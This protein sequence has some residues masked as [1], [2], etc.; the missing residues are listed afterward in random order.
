VEQAEPDAK[1]YREPIIKY[2]K[3]E[4]ERDDKVMPSTLRGSRPVMPS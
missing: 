3:N 1:D 2:I 4:E